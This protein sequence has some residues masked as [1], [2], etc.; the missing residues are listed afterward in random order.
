MKFVFSVAL[1]ALATTSPIA[2]ATSEIVALAA[3]NE[4]AKRDITENEYR[5][6]GCRPVIFFFARGSTEIGNMGTVVG[7]GVCDGLK[8]AY[9]SSK[10]ACQIVVGGYSQG[11]AL[12]HRAVEGR[13]SS[14]KNKVVGAVTFG[15]TQNL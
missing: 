6:Y 1:A 14:V 9:G 13:S 5:V 12:T 4:I 11:A 8:S 10:V 7:L 2:P 3:R 15:D